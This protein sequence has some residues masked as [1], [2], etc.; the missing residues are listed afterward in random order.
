VVK[1]TNNAYC[2]SFETWSSINLKMGY[3]ESILG[4]KL[5]FFIVELKFQNFTRIKKD[6]KNFK[7]L[8]YKNNPNIFLRKYL[9]VFQLSLLKAPTILATY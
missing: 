6:R 9:F 3:S 1:S 4:R 8:L 2:V 5:F 7:G